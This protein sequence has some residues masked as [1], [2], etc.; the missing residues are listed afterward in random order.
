MKKLKFTFV[1]VFFLFAVQLFGQPQ[2]IH[3]QKPGIEDLKMTV[4]QDEPD[5]PAVI[6]ERYADVYFDDWREELRLFYNYRERIKILK[7]EG[8][9]YT[10]FRIPYIGYDYF[11]DFTQIRG[12]IYRLVNGKMRKKNLGKR[13]ITRKKIDNYNY[14]LEI[15][16]P[17]VKVGDIIEIRYTLATFNFVQPRRFYFQEDIPVRHAEFNANI[18]YFMKY[19]FDVYRFDAMASKTMQES[20]AQIEWSA[21]YKDPIPAGLS[22]RGYNFRATTSLNFPSNYY[23]LVMEDVPSFV[24]EKYLDNP[25]NYYYHVDMKL[26]QLQRDIGYYNQFTLF[27]WE[28]FSNRMYQTTVMGYRPMT[29]F[30]AQSRPYPA[31]FII[32]DATSWDLLAK[33]LEK[34]P[35][36]GRQLKRYAGVLPV[37]NRLKKEHKDTLD[38]AKAIY[39]WVQDSI[40]WNGHYDFLVSKNLSKVVKTREG[41]SADLN[42]LLVY[43]LR[44]AG[45]KAN[46]V[47]IRT[48]DKGHL[49]KDLAAFYQFNHVIASAYI[50]NHIVLLDAIGEHPWFIL[51]QKDLNQVGVLVAKDTLFLASINHPIL[52]KKIYSINAIVNNNNQ[53]SGQLTYTLTGL[54]SLD[55]TLAQPAISTDYA[56][57]VPG[58]VNSNDGIINKTYTI[59]ADNLI[60]QTDTSYII[61]PFAL[62]DDIENIFNSYSRNYPVYLGHRWKWTYKVTIT[63]PEKVR[64]QYLPPV[65]KSINGATLTLNS[66]IKRKQVVITLNLDMDRYYF[67]VNEYEKLYNLLQAFG[68]MRDASIVID[69]T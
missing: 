8:A 49:I 67:D 16:F 20:F 2:K 32:F 42:M 17:D 26:Q 6:L 65:K 13:Y 34:D 31:G 36:F 47:L 46:P 58:S 45:I 1:F 24:P 19:Y 10:Y 7:P 63:L 28:K 51:P 60:S 38:L 61:K 33:N 11:E 48:L 23:H 66:E 12:S 27:L 30:L 15:R 41:N 9:K 62:F 22:H 29:K 44:R 55:S 39:K 37:V 64:Q 25:K 54:Y 5:A 21:R 18:P 4:D 35:A 52:P 14:V 50:D 69:R 57:L 53:I 56:S 68:Q 3:W 40:K 59:V 43:M